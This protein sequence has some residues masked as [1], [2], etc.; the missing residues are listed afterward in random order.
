MRSRPSSVR[1]RAAPTC[2]E[3]KKVLGRAWVLARH[4]DS[5]ACCRFSIQR[6]S[7]IVG[8]KLPARDAVLYSLLWAARHHAMVTAKEMHSDRTAERHLSSD[9]RFRL[10]SL[11]HRLPF[12]AAAMVTF[13]GQRNLHVQLVSSISSQLEVPLGGYCAVSDSVLVQVAA[14]KLHSNRPVT[15]Q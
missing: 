3:K 10:R 9:C 7:I 5:E 8:S 14:Q 6:C 2:C 12:T 13:N 4:G 11:P 1:R 15:T